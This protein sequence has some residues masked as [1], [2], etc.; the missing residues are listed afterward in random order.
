M[1]VLVWNAPWTVQGDILF[2][3]NCFLKHLLLQANL[4]ANRGIEVDLL[5]NDF[6][7]DKSAQIADNINVINVTAS[8]IMQLTQGVPTPMVS[9]YKKNNP[10]FISRIKE[11]LTPKLSSSYDAI[12]VWEN[13]VPFLEEMYPESVIVHQ[14]PGALS[15]APF[16]ST[17]TI[18][19]HGLYK[20]G[21]IHRLSD[22][23]LLGD[24]SSD[25]VSTFKTKIKDIYSTLPNLLEGTYEAANF[26]QI[27]LLP[28]QVSN[29]YAFQADTSYITQTDYLLDVLNR[30]PIQTGVIA[31]QYV[32]AKISDTVI[33]PDSYNSLKTHWPNLVFHEKFDRTPNIS[34]HLLPHVG[35]VITCSSSVGIQAMIW[36]K[37]LEIYG[38]TFLQNYSTK[39]IK[40]RGI[41]IESAHNN[42]LGFIFGRQQVLSTRL[43]HDDAFLINL[44][45]ELIR[46]KKENREGTDSFAKF[47]DIDTE[48]DSKLLES[49]NG[50]RL[51]S[52]FK[53]ADSSLD[54]ELQTIAKF[55]RSIKN[56]K[57]ESISFDVFDTL[58]SRAVEVPADAYQFL[59]TEALK[60]SNGKTEDFARVRLV[61]EVETRNSSLEGEIT[62]NQIYDHIQQHYQ[63]PLELIEQIKNREIELEIGLVEQ[64]TL[65][66]KL[67]NVALASKKP[68]TIISD[69]Y[70]PH[71]VVE[72][73]LQ[74][75]G[76]TGYKKLYV[77]SQY[78]CRKKEGP[79]FDI[80][81]EDQSL[82]PTLHLHVGDNKAADVDMP[83]ERGMHAFRI[84]RAVDRMRSNVHYKKLFNPRAGVGQKSRS[85]IAG[86]IAQRFFD[87]PSGQLEQETLF[88]G[89]NQRIGYAALGPMLVAY[90]Q[91]LTRKAKAD[92]I[93]RLYFLSREGWILKEVYD[94][95]NKD[96]PN[97]VPSSY[98]YCSR[99]AA[100]VS[101]IEH[102]S[103]V[104]A[105]ASQPYEAGV[106]L[107]RLLNQRFGLNIDAEIEQKISESKF[108]SSNVILESDSIARIEFTQLCVSLSSYILRQAQKERKAYLTYLNEAGITNEARPAVVDIGWKANMQGSLG[109]LIKRPLDGYYYATLQGVD[110]WELLGHTVSAFAGESV[111]VD[112]SSAAINNRH[113][114]EFLTCKADGSL[115]NFS[116]DNDQALKANFRHDEGQSKRNILIEEIH[117]GVLEF[118]SDV[119]YRFGPF[120]DNLIIDPVLGER[121]FKSY[122]ESPTKPDAS[123]LS[124]YSFEDSFGGVDKKFIIN[125]KN[126]ASSVWKKGAAAVSSAQTDETEGSAGQAKPKSKST[127]KDLPVT[128]KSSGR[129][130]QPTIGEMRPGKIDGF[131]GFII[132][133]LEKMVVRLTSNKKK[134]EKYKRDRHAFFLDSKDKLATSWYGFTNPE[135]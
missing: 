132:K 63:A 31:T 30:T 15:R 22:E 50:A 87:L 127:S 44:L 91:W 101:A 126:P 86:L 18:D 49:I 12:L 33:T 5:V 129:P 36:S 115:I 39:N 102:T 84:P 16:P 112:H 106:E 72:R 1:K 92:N 104:T 27:A 43:V 54:A 57:I 52:T 3:K 107:G 105:V 60:L 32:T 79:L 47:S 100:R 96:R 95:L 68:I 118:A 46:K 110:R 70:L 29:H 80:V 97:A 61:A 56:N 108:G 88:M 109:S 62:L 117:R 121:I 89:I 133:P 21:S 48:Y 17:T 99:R 103:D 81:I 82:E 34:Q 8:D 6:I 69:M 23:I 13:P 64:R 58:I 76:Y 25:T 42:L 124:D 66:R 120:L 78:G 51:F 35:K 94:R 19:V 65:G 122:M 41:E 28:L 7:N 26:N 37:E 20:D 135:N 11:Y 38:D 40:S 119:A 125:A 85:V 73:M 59:E 55:E 53:V 134:Y 90:M 113:L 98:L 9:L 71:D 111:S 83:L 93:S 2:F 130:K 14:M 77:S 67:W 116:F 10:A 74:K 4:L 123:L 114:C 75:T 131:P 128:I 24:F 45:E